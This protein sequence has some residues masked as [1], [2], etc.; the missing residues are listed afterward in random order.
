MEAA[1]S[2]EMYNWA[3]T[4][5]MQYSGRHEVARGVVKKEISQKAGN[6]STYTTSIENCK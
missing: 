1:I 4:C 6:I 3:P 2:S 5:K